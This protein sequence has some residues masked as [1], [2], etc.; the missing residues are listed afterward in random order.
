VRIECDFTPVKLA[1]LKPL[2]EIDKTIGG[3]FEALDPWVV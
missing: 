1:V 3:L 2:E